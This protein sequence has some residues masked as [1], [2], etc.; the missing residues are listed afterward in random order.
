MAKTVSSRRKA[1]KAVAS[2]NPNI[3]SV[4]GVTATTSPEMWVFTGTNKLYKTVAVQEFDVAQRADFAS[5]K[6][7]TETVR[8]AIAN[9]LPQ[10]DTVDLSTDAARQKFADIMLQQALKQSSQDTRA[11]IGFINAS[12]V[13][14]VIMGNSK[15]GN[16]GPDGTPK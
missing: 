7:L 11:V 5:A 15:M 10:A 8:L 4:N 12:E 14:A 1:V 6:A 2:F 13:Y 16:S 9:I 3:V